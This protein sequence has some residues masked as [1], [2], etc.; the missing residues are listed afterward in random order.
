VIVDHILLKVLVT[1]EN[2]PD[3]VSVSVVVALGVEVALVCSIVLV[4]RVDC[5]PLEVSVVK[6]VC[7]GVIE[8]LGLPLVDSKL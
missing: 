2:I 3:V 7:S 4:A 6:V 1:V 8:T 5:V